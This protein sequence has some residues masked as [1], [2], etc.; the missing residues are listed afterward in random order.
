MWGRKSEKVSWRGVG[1]SW[2]ELRSW[3]ELKRGGKRWDDLRRGG[4]NQ[5]SWAQVRKGGKSWKEVGRGEK[6]WDELGNVEKEVGRGEK[7]WDDLRQVEKSCWEEVG[8]GGTRIGWGEL[9]RGEKS[10][11]EVGR[12]EAPWEQLTEKSCEKKWEK[13][14]WGKVRTSAK[15]SW[16]DA[17]LHCNSYRQN[18]SL[19]PIVQ[20]SLLLETSVTRLV[21]ILLY[22]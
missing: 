19:T 16:E 1:K 5:K 18:L 9:R 3:G 17:K 13:L 4:G 20:H 12:D 21:R 8:R 6:N 11:A 14:R 7:T 2:E 15:R 22:L 10:W